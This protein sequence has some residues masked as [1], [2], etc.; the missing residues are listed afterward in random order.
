MKKLTLLIP[1]K[2]ENESLPQVLKEL[3][4]YKPSKFKPFY[5]TYI[6]ERRRSSQNGDLTN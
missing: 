2:N 6:H 4:I 3:E 5:A 1:A